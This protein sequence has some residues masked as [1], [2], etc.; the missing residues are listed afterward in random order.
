V[1]INLQ[2]Q[3]KSLLESMDRRAKLQL[4]LQETVEGLSVAAI[5]YYSVS[6]IGYLAKAGKE[7]GWPIEPELVVGISIPVVAIIL[8]A[9]VRYMRKSIAKGQPVE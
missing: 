8:T 7:M 6:L 2:R 3:N 5:T 1:E 9:G 4:R